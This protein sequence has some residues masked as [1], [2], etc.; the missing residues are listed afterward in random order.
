MLEEVQKYKQELNTCLLLIFSITY[1]TLK[2]KGLS[3]TKR[4]TLYPSS[5]PQWTSMHCF[6]IHFWE[7]F[8]FH[9]EIA[10]LFLHIQI[11]VSFQFGEANCS[12]CF[13]MKIEWISVTSIRTAIPP[14]A[15]TDVLGTR[16]SVV[17]NC[18]T[19][20]WAALKNQLAETIRL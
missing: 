9:L 13:H 14:N 19:P 15:F 8:S 3:V 10:V 12:L 5:V 6:S 11:S 20:E 18:N 7:A 16:S 1:V 2:V 17:C 4:R